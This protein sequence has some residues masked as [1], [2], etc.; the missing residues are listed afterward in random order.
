MDFGSQQDSAAPKGLLEIDDCLDADGN[1][2]L[3]PGTTLISLIERNV[4]N[5]G[6]LVAFR[7]L[8]YARSEGQAHEVTWTEFGVRLKAISAR[9]Q[10]FAGPGDRVAVLAPQGINWVAGFYAAIKAGSIAVPL[11]APELPGHAERLD[12]AL[13]DS[14]PTAVLTTTA[15]KES[16][17]NFL[18]GRTQLHQP[19]VIVIDEIPDSA[20]EQFRPV[21]LDLDAVSYLQYTSGATRPPV[22]VEITHRAV[23]TNLVQMILSID[24]LNRNTHGVSWLPLYHDMGLS[25]IGFPAVYGGHTTLMSPTAFVRRPQRW[26]QAL[27]AGSRTG[28]VV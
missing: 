18:A 12:I 26:I 25:M 4:A 3:P 13:R 20:G 14:Q 6:D 10:Q 11:F 7:Y 5:I 19:Q 8:D 23:E 27:S 1:I 24:L 28:R 22:G 15:G 9:V 21:E 16:I 2:A 17:E